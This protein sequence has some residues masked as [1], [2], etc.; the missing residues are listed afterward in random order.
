MLSSEAK[1]AKIW[2]VRSDPWL[3]YLH[4]LWPGAECPACA[5][6]RPWRPV[7][8]LLGAGKPTW[9]TPTTAA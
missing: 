3:I 7:L 8:G 1:R 2:P 4:T 9:N 6:H 5:Q